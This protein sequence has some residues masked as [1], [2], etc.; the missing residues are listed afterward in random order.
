MESFYSQHS[1]AVDVKLP[2]SAEALLQY[3]ITCLGFLLTI[4]WVFPAFFFA[5]IPL[6]AVFVVFFLCF[7]AGIRR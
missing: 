2:F 4:V 1:F 6:A 5:C 7:R 3:M